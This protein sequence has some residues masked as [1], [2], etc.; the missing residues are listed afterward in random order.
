MLPSKSLL[1]EL[2]L[3]KRKE[4]QE[5][6]LISG[7]L[8]LIDFLFRLRFGSPAKNSH[9][10]AKQKKHNA[11][12]HINVHLFGDIGNIMRRHNAVGRHNDAYQQKENSNW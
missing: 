7:L 6:P 11:P 5:R 1:T 3:I 4:T 9:W 2:F 8:I 12:I 10:C